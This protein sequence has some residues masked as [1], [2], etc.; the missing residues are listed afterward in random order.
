MDGRVTLRVGGR[1]GRQISWSSGYWILQEEEEERLPE[2]GSKQALLPQRS[3][4]WAGAL[5]L[6]SLMHTPARGCPQPILK[7]GRLR[8]RAVR[9]AAE[10]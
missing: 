6:A 7:M 2:Q 1:E 9:V 5:P 10:G 3:E 8:Q 4:M